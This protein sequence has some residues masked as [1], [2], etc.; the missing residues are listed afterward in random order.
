MAKRYYWLRLKEDFFER[1][2]IKILENMPNG[3]DYIIFYMKLLLKS[4]STDGILIFNGCIPFTP[5][6]L[7][8]I[9]NTNVDTVKVAVDILTKLGLMEQWDDGKLFMV[10]TQNMIGSEGESASRVRALREKEKKQKEVKALQCNNQVTKS[11]TDIDIDID[12]DIK[13]DIDNTISKD[14]VSSTKVQPIIDAWNL[15]GLQRVISIK[16]GTNRYKLLN[17]RIKQ[18]GIENVLKAISNIQSSSFLKGQNNKSWVITFD[19]LIKPNNFIKVLECNYEDKKGEL[20]KKAKNEKAP[21]RFDNFKSREYDY[22]NLEKKL[23]GWEN[24][25]DE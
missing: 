13:I 17:A 22:D 21:L 18:Y 5:N 2:E 9:T 16:A 7:A 3:K 1:D 6:M 19:W 4:V 25:E 23:L 20:D 12:K 14:I 11:N 24:K 15:L 8:S 10:A